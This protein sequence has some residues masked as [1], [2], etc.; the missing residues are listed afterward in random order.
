[1]SYLRSTG[2]IFYAALSLA[3]AAALADVV[4]VV[5]AKS[6]ITALSKSQ[7]ADI[8]LGKISRAPDGT[9]LQPIDQAEGTDAREEFYSKVTGKSSAQ[10]KAY[11]A[12][13][14]FTGRGKPPATVAN[15][16][17]AKQLIVRTPAAIG[18][19]D[20]SLVD[21]QLRIVF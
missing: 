21:E 10:I 5:P 7:L 17:E 14:I 6:P 12:R 18:Y 19:I 3:S 15:G 8:F 20:R 9:A 16:S 1:M 11:W 2:L 13:I 4:A